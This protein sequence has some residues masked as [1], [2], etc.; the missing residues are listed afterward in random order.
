MSGKSSPEA[1]KFGRHLRAR[2]KRLDPDACDQHHGQPNILG[3]VSL[4]EQRNADHGPWSRCVILKLELAQYNAPS[5]PPPWRG[6]LGASRQ[7]RNQNRIMPMTTAEI[8]SLVATKEIFRFLPIPPAVE[9]MISRLRS[10]AKV[11]KSVALGPRDQIGRTKAEPSL[12]A[13]TTT[14]RVFWR[15]R[16]DGASTTAEPKTAAQ[17][18]D[19]YSAPSGTPWREGGGLAATRTARKSARK[20]GSIRICG[21]GVVRSYI[22]GSAVWT[23]PSQTT[24]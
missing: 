16:P 17:R 9:A 6:D 20:H 5:P 7:L 4:R 13:A 11:A 3:D 14:H 22:V 19:P 10:Q 15:T 2:H 24:R 8:M 21:R 12:L 23:G 1:G 18:H